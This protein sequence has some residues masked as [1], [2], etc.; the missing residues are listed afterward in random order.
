MTE[1]SEPPRPPQY[2][3]PEI[4]IGFEEMTS[5]IDSTPRTW[6]HTVTLSVGVSNAR[7]WDMVYRT[8]SEI[9][10]DLGYQYPY[11]SVSS[12]QNEDIDAPLEEID[13]YESIGRL[14]M[15]QYQ[16]DFKFHLEDNPLDLN[17]PESLPDC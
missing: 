7:D 4:K 10:A 9:G 11:V 13:P 5:E 2:S 3:D 17:P 8:L 14:K 1:S 16:R 15:A 6:S 12:M